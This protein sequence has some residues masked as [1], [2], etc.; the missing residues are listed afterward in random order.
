MIFWIYGMRKRTN[1]VNPVNP[2]KKGISRVQDNK[3]L[4]ITLSS[5][6]GLTPSKIGSTCASTT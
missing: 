1:P 4:A 2:V 3:F 6:I 5:R